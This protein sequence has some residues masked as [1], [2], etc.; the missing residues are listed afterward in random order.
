MR[1]LKPIMLVAALSVVALRDAAAHGLDGADGTAVGSPGWTLDPWIVV[2]LLASALLFGIGWSRLR[3]RSRHHGERWPRRALLFTAGWLVIAA[4][5]VSPLHAAGER[6]FAAHML[7][8]ESLMLLGAPLMVLAEPL[9]VLLWA[10][11]S[12]WRRRIA[13]ATT[14]RG[15]TRIWAR[16]TES[17]TAT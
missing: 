1:S 13:A 6:S 11:P 15:I 17:F 16:A 10:L 14:N 2:P 3:A 4:A 8:H 12:A 9:V 7:E 5:L